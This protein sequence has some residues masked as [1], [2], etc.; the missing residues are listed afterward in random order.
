MATIIFYA[1]NFDYALTSGEKS[2]SE[3]LEAANMIQKISTRSFKTYAQ[4]GKT[5]DAVKSRTDMSNEIRFVKNKIA[6]DAYNF[7]CFRSSF[8][9]LFNLVDD[10]YSQTIDEYLTD[11]GLKVLPTFA[12]NSSRFGQTISE[13]NIRGY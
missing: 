11:N 2:A 12:T 3:L 6:K 5:I 7:E 1:D 10:W 8:L 9:G 13:S 4:L